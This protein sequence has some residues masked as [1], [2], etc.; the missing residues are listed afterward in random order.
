MP[1]AVGMWGAVA[2]CLD[3]GPNSP[4]E[5]YLWAEG[6]PQAPQL[7]LI[8]LGDGLILEGTWIRAVH[9]LFGNS[10]VWVGA[11]EGGCH[12]KTPQQARGR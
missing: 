3:S 2:L 12:N 8:H 6:R 9:A 10:L 11:W 5:R 1:A 7:A 4:P